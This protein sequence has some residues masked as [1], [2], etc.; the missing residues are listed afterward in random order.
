MQSFLLG[1]FEIVLV[2]AIQLPYT[3]PYSGVKLKVTENVW[4]MIQHSYVL[5]CTTFIS[6]FG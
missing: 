2:S 4:L 6:M 1:P 3:V 5:H